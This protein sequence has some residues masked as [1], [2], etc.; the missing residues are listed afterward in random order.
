MSKFTWKLRAYR[1]MRRRCGFARR[2]MVS[3]LY[4]TFPRWSPEAAVNEDLSYWG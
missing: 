4:E 3:S 1:Y 2:D